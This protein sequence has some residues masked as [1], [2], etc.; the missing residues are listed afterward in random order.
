MPSTEAKAPH[1][2][3]E[4]PPPEGARHTPADAHASRDRLLTPQEAA[5]LIHVSRSTLLRWAREGR[6]A[7]VTIPSGRR[8]FRLGDLP[9]FGDNHVP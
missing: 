4:V 6:L 5:D 9:G 8:R 7:S 1:P 2:R 3:P